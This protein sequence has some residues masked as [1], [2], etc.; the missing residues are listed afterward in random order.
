MQEIV[1]EF[2]ISE[3]PCPDVD[4]G[5]NQMFRLI[6]NH[7]GG[8]YAR[9]ECASCKRFIKW[10]G[11]PKELKAVDPRS[12]VSK[13]LVARYSQGFCELCLRRKEDLPEPQTLEGH[14]KVQVSQGGTDDRENLWIL[15]TA[16][17]RWIHWQRT[18]T[19]HYHHSD[20]SQSA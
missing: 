12:E 9:I 4:C 2:F 10:E 11:K 19:G 5:S 18:Y 8:H 7:R 3:T 13:K 1:K 14:H 17:H 15:C 16:C 6:G 20:D